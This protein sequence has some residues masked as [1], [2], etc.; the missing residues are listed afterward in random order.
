MTRSGGCLCGSVR[1]TLD[2]DP[3]AAAICHCRNCQKQSGST[4]S[5]NWVLPRGAVQVEGDLA[6]YEDR[7]DSGA[8]V[9]RQFC[10]NC[11]SA[12]R[13]LA[14]SMP[15]VEIL[16][17]GSL[18]ETPEIA[19][20]AEIYMANAAGWEKTVATWPRLERGQG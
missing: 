5:V 15:Q 12:I 9:L 8:A 16:K 2:T 13:T 17:V 18:D 19:P 10:P 1:Y 14:E 11:G 6:T 3:M 7:G 4:R 20:V